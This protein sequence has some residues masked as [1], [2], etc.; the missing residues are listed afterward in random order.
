VKCTNKGKDNSRINVIV[1][2]QCTT[3]INVKVAN[4]DD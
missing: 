4:I 3:R 1:N 2:I